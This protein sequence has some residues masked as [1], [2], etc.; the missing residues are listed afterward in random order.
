MMQAL[1]AEH[2][3]HIHSDAPSALAQ[4]IRQQ[5]LDAFY[6]NTDAWKNAVLRQAREAF[7]QA[8]DGLNA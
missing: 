3:L 4:Q 7:F 5:M 2:W 1:R 6:V 8:T